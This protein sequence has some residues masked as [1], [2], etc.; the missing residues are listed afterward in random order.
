MDKTI[1]MS[2]INQIL[3]SYC[4]GCF[5]KKQLAKDNGKTNAHKFCI[6]GCTVG[7]QLRFLGNE[8]N[9]IISR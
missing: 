4:E 2:D 5:L 7:E 1:V 9:K 3:D 8:M 6:S